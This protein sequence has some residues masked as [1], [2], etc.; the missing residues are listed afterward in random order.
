MRH[1]AIAVA[2]GLP[3]RKPGPPSKLFLRMS[4]TGGD[5]KALVV[6]NFRDAAPAPLGRSLAEASQ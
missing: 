4:L 5:G 6:P 2:S 3:D 1:L